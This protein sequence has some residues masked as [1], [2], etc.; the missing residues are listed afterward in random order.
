MKRILYGFIGLIIALFPNLVLA[1]PSSVVLTL[2]ATGSAQ[3]YLNGNAINTFTY[4]GRGSSAQSFTFTGTQIGYLDSTGNVLAVKVSATSSTSAWVSWSLNITDT[5]S[6]IIT[7]DNTSSIVSYSSLCSP[8]DPLAWTSSVFTPDTSWTSPVDETYAIAGARIIDLTTGSLLSCLTSIYESRVSSCQTL[9]F[10][11]TFSLAT[12]QTP[13][14]SAPNFTISKSAKP[15][16]GI[17]GNQSLTFTLG[18]CNSGGG[19]SA[20]VVTVKD[21]FID[22]D[23]VFSYNSILPS[24][25]GYIDASNVS[26]SDTG[27][28]HAD[29]SGNT[30]TFTFEKGFPAYSCYNLVYTVKA[31]SPVTSF[32]SAWSNMAS[33]AFGTQTSVATVVLTNAAA[34]YTRTSTPTLAS[35]ATFTATPT[36]TPIWTGSKTWTLTATS[37]N[38]PTITRTLT[39]VPTIYCPN[40]IINT[41][42]PNADNYGCVDNQGNFW[43]AS[44]Y[45]SSLNEISP[46]GTLLHTYDGTAGHEN[47][48]QVIVV[49]WDGRYIWLGASDS[50]LTKFDPLTGHSVKK[51]DMFSSGSSR[52]SDG[53]IQD[54]VYDGT[55]LWIAMSRAL[56]SPDGYVLKFNSTT[57]AVSLTITGQTNVNGLSLANY[58]GTKYILSAYAGIAG[59][60]QW[61]KININTGM[62]T[63]YNFPAVNGYRITN[64]NLFVYIASYTNGNITKF[65]INT[66]AIVATWTSGP[67]LNAIAYDGSYVWVVG[68]DNAIN[69]HDKNTGTIVCNLTS[70]MG[71]NTCLFY[72]GANM[73]TVGKW[74]GSY[75]SKL[76]AINA[77]MTPTITPTFYIPPPTATMTAISTPYLQDLGQYKVGDNNTRVLQC[78]LYPD[79]LS[80]LYVVSYGATLQ[81]RQ[82]MD[83]TW[84][85]S[86]SP[87][88]F[89]FPLP[90]LKVSGNYPVQL[91]VQTTS[92]AT[93]LNSNIITVSPQ[94]SPT[95]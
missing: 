28:I 70:G 36:I 31:T 76:S 33:L 24:I 93:T 78:Q 23:L 18:I 42:V 77:T 83:N 88:R 45:D 60:S 27:Y 47:F 41:S 30:T 67:N 25:T 49:S 16:S 50:Y 1:A 95:P 43:I 81:F 82:F 17:L 68:G 12:A 54:I 91:Q 89:T 22:P 56:A 44:F 5:N 92:P 86:N 39:T 59:T 74:Y 10:R 71:G 35:T 46:N 58:Y 75:V 29:T 64:D 94:Q 53:G 61:S 84:N 9:W 3:V 66:G 85:T 14:P 38:T 6:T 11:Q 37:T 79:Y 15:S 72:D 62:F 52:G 87:D 51:Y 19:A 40:P 48:G 90:N 55:N 32:G 65:D 26:S 8:H 2:N 69:I 13:T 4:V 21:V 63:S 20:D 7:S 73:W 57:E 80:P 34:G